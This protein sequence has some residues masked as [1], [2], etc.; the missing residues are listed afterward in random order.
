MDEIIDAMTR[1]NDDVV[2][3][4]TEKDVFEMRDALASGEDKRV[5]TFPPAACP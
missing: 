3:F 1:I 4:M 5:F 2:F